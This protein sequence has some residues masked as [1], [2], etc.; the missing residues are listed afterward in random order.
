M[1]N[2]INYTKAEKI[3][4]FKNEY[5]SKLNDAMALGNTIDKAPNYLN[6]LR[7]NES[8]ISRTLEQLE[9]LALLMFFI[10]EDLEG[11]DLAIKEV[12]KY[13]INRFSN[14]SLHLWEYEQNC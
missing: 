7:D 5:L 6:A 9:D 12:I 14:Y 13:L 11:D 4:I 10:I 2:Y 3:A 8:E 1:L